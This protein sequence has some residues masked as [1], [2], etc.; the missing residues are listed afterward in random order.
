MKTITYTCHE[1]ASSTKHTVALLK[2]LQTRASSVA[3]AKKAEKVIF[4]FPSGSKWVFQFDTN[5][6]AIGGKINSGPYGE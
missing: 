6:E 1:V 2:I 5:G 3:K 4:E